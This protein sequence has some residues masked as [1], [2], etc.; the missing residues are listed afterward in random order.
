MNP[1]NLEDLLREQ[2]GAGSSRPLPSR[3]FEDRVRLSL[4]AR[5]ARSW[6][7]RAH[8]LEGLAAIAA[9]LALAVVTLPWLIGPRP[10]VRGG[11]GG[12]SPSSTAEPTLTPTAGPL[13]HAQKWDLA[14]D[15]PADWTLVENP[16]RGANWPTSIGDPVAFGFVG[17]GS[18]Q[19]Q[20]CTTN[21]ST[22]RESCT[23]TWSLSEGTI[24]LRFAAA[25]MGMPLDHLPYAWTG[26]QALQG[27]EIPGAEPVNIDGFPARFA[28]N[29]SDVVPYSTETVLGA[30]EIM[31]W[32]LPKPVQLAEGYIIVAAIRG[33]N[34]AE[35]EA[36]AR[37]LVASI[38]Y[39]P[40]PM[41][42]PTDPAALAQARQPALLK[43]F[44]GLPIDGSAAYKDSWDCFPR[45]VGVSQQANIIAFPDQ[46]PLTRPLSVTCTT[47][48]MDPD[49]MQGWTVTLRQS[50][51]AGPDYPAGQL[52]TVCR[53]APDGMAHGC[54]YGFDKN[55]ITTYPH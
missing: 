33:P 5:G 49:P 45:A 14:F 13:A 30:T 9:V 44:S 39:V 19:Q 16:N 35:L 21:P 42:L 51:R 55:R 28:T 32:G 2:L 23:T 27:P 12:A 38:Q 11:G 10:D 18:G 3:G 6:R 41:M 34:A 8:A 29:A 46:N 17:T 47:V 7:W 48:S 40:E 37:A 15:Y 4:T 1:M 20:K 54:S 50:W 22:G 52:D 31:W 26:Y 24:V 25:P 53:A 36:Q 43:F